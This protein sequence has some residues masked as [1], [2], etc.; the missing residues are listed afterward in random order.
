MTLKLTSNALVTLAKQ[1]RI[2][3]KNCLKLSTSHAT[4]PRS[5]R[6][7]CS[8]FQTVGPATGKARGRPYVLSRQRGT[9]CLKCFC[10][11]RRKLLGRAGH[12]PPTFWPRWAFV[13]CDYA[14]QMVKYC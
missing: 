11:R 7:G 13:F 5:S 14:R 6:T 8:E 2:V 1:N 9:M 10:Y 4:S 3:L 12:C